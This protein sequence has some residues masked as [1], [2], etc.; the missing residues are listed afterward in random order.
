MVVTFH[1]MGSPDHQQVQAALTHTKTGAIN[2]QFNHWSTVHF[3]T[4]DLGE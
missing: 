2:F 4:R 1:V 3:N